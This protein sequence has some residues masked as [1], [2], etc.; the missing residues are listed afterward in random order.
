MNEF[1]HAACLPTKPAKADTRCYASGW[2]KVKT[3]RESTE[4]MFAPLDILDYDECYNEL[5]KELIL[6][7]PEKFQK[8]YDESIRWDLCTSNRPKSICPGDSG[9]PFIC[10]EDGKAV[11][12]GIASSIIRGN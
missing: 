2:G 3:Y 11:V 9:G 1:V 6:L 7:D 4:L 8:H 10:D 5:D 12:H